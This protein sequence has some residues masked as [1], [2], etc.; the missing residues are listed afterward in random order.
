MALGGAILQN[1]LRNRLPAEFLVRFPQGVAIVYSAIPQIPQLTQPLKDQV[2]QAFID[3]LRPVWQ[4]LAA[5]CGVGLLS[6]LFMRS[7]PL[8]A[9][10]DDDWAP[11]E[12]V[13][14]QSEY[15]E[16]SSADSRTAGLQRRVRPSAR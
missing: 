8:H 14:Q 16:M 15:M 3:S 13:A 2:H 7:L 9:T 12:F 4:A 1:E 5:I 6:T 11:P 10:T